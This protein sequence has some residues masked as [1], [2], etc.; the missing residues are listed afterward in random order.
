M[1]RN[2]FMGMGFVTQKGVIHLIHIDGVKNV[3]VG[4]RD[5]SV[6]H[7][8]AVGYRQK[9]LAGVVASRIDRLPPL[10]GD[11]KCHPGSHGDPAEWR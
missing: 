2:A 10:R 9:A 7:G 8:S 11:E 1:G 3:E 5:Q 6:L 4:E